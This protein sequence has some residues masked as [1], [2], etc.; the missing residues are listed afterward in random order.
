[1]N[2]T[3]VITTSDIVLGVIFGFAF[4]VFVGSL[5]HRG[6]MLLV[7]KIKGHAEANQHLRYSP[8]ARNWGKCVRCGTHVGYP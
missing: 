6:V 4:L 7:C 5:M 8:G 3:F 1:M 2:T